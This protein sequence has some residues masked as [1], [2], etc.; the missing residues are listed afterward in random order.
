MEKET[1]PKGLLPLKGV[2]NFRDMGGLKT[3][4]GRTVKR[5]ILFRA[6]ELTGL[7]AEDLR[8]L[9]SMNIQYVYDYRDKDEADKKPDPQI[10]RARHERIPVNG[11]DKTTAHTEW[12]PGTF[13]QTFTREKFTKVYAQMPIQNTSYKR[14]LSLLMRPEKNLPLVHHCTGGRDRTGVGAMLILITLGVPVETIMEDYLLSNETLVDF[15]REVFEDAAN[16]LFGAAL[17]RFEKDFLLHEEYLDASIRSI[18]GAYGSF[19]GYLEREFG[20]TPA[21]REKI[22]DFCLE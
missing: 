2:F 10:G 18:L 5:G 9:R 13:Y 16:Y 12:D 20:M 1:L 21:I 17:K 6:A 19:A 4:D 7:T 22:K 11:S 8:H 3:M 14:M 15:H